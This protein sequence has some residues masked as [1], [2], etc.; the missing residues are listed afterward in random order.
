MIIGII[1]VGLML[2]SSGLK[3]TEHE[4]GQQLQTDLL[5][6][7]GFIGWALAIIALGALGFIPIFEKASK[8]LL[9]LLF[10][11]ILVRNGGVFEQFQGAIQDAVATGPAPSVAPVPLASTGGSGSGTGSGSGSSSSASSGSGVSSAVSSIASIG[12]MAAML[13]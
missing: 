5:G 2:L 11:V 10:V 13:L 12:M 9:L 8:Y 7:G 4:L 6:T 1:I 3:G